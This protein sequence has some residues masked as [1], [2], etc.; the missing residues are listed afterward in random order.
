MT[1]HERERE[2]L[3]KRLDKEMNEMWAKYWGDRMSRNNF[4]LN[5]RYGLH[6][7]TDRNAFYKENLEIL[8]K[9]K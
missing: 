8:E 5:H 4:A 6:L 2:Y 1:P 9:K 7:P 3:A